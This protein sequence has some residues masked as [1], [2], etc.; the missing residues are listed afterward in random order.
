MARDLQ[1]V[2]A[3]IGHVYQ[4]AGRL[5]AADEAEIR[6]LGLSPKRA[7][8]R[9]YRNSVL[10]RAALIDGVCAAMWGVA[11]GRVPGASLLGRVATPWLHTAAAVEAVPYAYVKI[12]KAE[13]AA[14]TA[15]YPVLI[16]YVAASYVKAVRFLGLIGFTV[17]DERVFGSVGGQYRRYHIGLER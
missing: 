3:Q 9:G 17:D 16:G 10:C 4:L 14:M 1:V 5:R 11:I 2:P 6:G 13:V 15:L 12:G 8:Y 7:L